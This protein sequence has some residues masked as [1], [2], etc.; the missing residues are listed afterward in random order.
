MT[1]IQRNGE[2]HQLGERVF[3][4]GFEPGTCPV[5]YTVTFDI[6]GVVVIFIIFF[7]VKE[8]LAFRSFSVIDLAMHPSFQVNYGL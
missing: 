3:L 1:C 5:H 8:G 2:K 7:Q 6:V 4:Q